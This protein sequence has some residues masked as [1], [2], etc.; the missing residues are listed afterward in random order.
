MNHPVPSKPGRI[1]YGWYIVAAGFA[2]LSI[3]YGARYS[4]AVFFPSVIAQFGWPRDLAASIL[5]LHIICY[6][7]TA[8]F[9]GFLVD[10]IGPKKSMLSGTVL[11]ASGM[12]LSGFSQE[13]W[14]FYLTFGLLAGVGLSLL[15]SAPLT[16]IIRNWF[17]QRRG[18]AISL[19]FLGEGAAY[20]C[21]PAVVWL[22]QS[23]GWRRAISLEGVI[24][25]VVFIP[26][27]LLVMESGPKGRG[28]EKD[29]FAPG[30]G[31]GQRRAESEARRIVDHDWAARDWS[32][33][34]AVK[35]FRYFLM[36]LS[37]FCVWGLSHH[38]LVTHQ[39]AFAM[40]AGYP[41]LYASSVISLGGPAFGLGCLVS[42]IS[43]R[44]GRE[45]SM[46]WGTLI[47][48]SGV[49]AFVLI[50][51]SSVPWLLYYYA[52][53]FGFGFGICVPMVA[54]AVT[55]IFQGAHSGATIGS[56]WLSF[57]LGGALGPWLGGWFF[58]LFGGYKEVFIL[59]AG[60]HLLGC[61]AVWLAGP[62]KIR[63]VPGR[64]RV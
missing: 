48:V 25:A 35:T 45:W 62:R 42:V 3:G 6:G 58:E 19:L 1:F 51:D 61:L 4:Y 22:I 46:T 2:L 43:D 16:V 20:A 8:P 44:I 38:I 32:L 50:K 24:V 36:C 28:L 23:F 39:I 30:S 7:L 52:L 53:A 59:A 47:S 12:I 60:V 18:T 27:L 54:A 13:P 29:G 14:H 10:R 40:D 33:I 15:A 57:A 55:D 5:S 11:L 49:A 64:V 31:S 37:S 17:E 26:L 41:R 63:L 9:S 34:R 21:Y 56:V